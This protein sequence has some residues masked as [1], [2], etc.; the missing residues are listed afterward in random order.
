MTRGLRRGSVADLAEKLR[1]ASMASLCVSEKS[2]SDTT[3]GD[4]CAAARAAA[5]AAQAEAEEQRLP[6]QL[7]RQRR[8]Q[9]YAEA[10]LKEPEVLQLQ[11]ERLRGGGGL[12]DYVDE[13]ESEEDLAELAELFAEFDGSLEGIIQQH[14]V[15]SI[16]RLLG[17]SLT[18]DEVKSLVSGLVPLEEQSLW[19]KPL[20]QR[21]DHR[22]SL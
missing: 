11:S 12:E 15:R 19:L 6:V 3:G 1:R 21:V 10:L 8:L 5:E 22:I 17:R 14:D 13:V 7:Q 2:E 4:N 9:V 16:M 18:E 20:Q